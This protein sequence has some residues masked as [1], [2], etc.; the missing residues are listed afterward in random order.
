MFP[1]LNSRAWWWPNHLNQ[2]CWGRV[3]SKTCRTG[4]QRDQDRNQDWGT[5]WSPEDEG[6]WL[7]IPLHFIQCHFSINISTSTNC[8][9]KHS[10]T[11]VYS[12]NNMQ[13]TLLRKWN[14]LLAFC[15]GW[16]PVFHCFK[17]NLSCL[18]LSD[19][20][21]FVDTIYRFA[22]PSTSSKLAPLRHSALMWLIL[23]LGP[24]IDLIQHVGWLSHY[25]VVQSTRLF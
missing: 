2:V 15:A 8:W 17:K 23:A 5:P 25:G 20:T 7:V 6:S 4:V 12:L 22:S 14:S 16:R 21:D 9:E 19:S 10:W 1:C 24:I 11:R 3:T 13:T 18:S